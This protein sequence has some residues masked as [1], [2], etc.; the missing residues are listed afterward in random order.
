MIHFHY[1]LHSFRT[2]PIAPAFTYSPLQRVSPRAAA[3]IPLSLS[4]IGCY[5]SFL[6]LLFLQI[7]VK[8]AYV[9]QIAYIPI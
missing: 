1:S 4:A 7:K 9:I 5:T 2:H 3:V 6:F 8:N